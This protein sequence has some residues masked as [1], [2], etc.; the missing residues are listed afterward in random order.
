MHPPIPVQPLDP[1]SR[2][3][4]LR[5]GALTAAVAPE[6]LTP[7]RRRALSREANALLLPAHHL[8]SARRENLLMELPGR[9]LG[10]RLYRPADPSPTGPA[11]DVLLVYF[12][13]GGWVVGD[14]EVHDNVCAFLAQYLGCRLLSMDYRKAPEHPFPAACDDAAD[15]YAWA[16]AQLGRWGCGRIAVAGN[17]AGGHLAAHALFANPA[18]VT[19]AALLFY[20][21]ADMDFGNTSYTQRGAGPGLTSAAMAWYWEQFL[22][23]TQPGDDARAVLMRQQWA[24]RRPPPTVLSIAWHDPL[25]DEGVAYAGL[26][27]RA[28]AQVRLLVAHDMAH[29]FVG[30]CRI[31]AS[32]RRHVEQ[33]ADSL[34]ECLG[35]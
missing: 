11:T 26:L 18:V 19:A 23:N 6:A 24:A 17:S 31:N 3:L 2:E 7:A 10:A 33:A 8:D 34:L 35:G 4:L 16:A 9:S 32:A 13:G 15:A 12:H 1:H 5:A 30:Q 28:G 14:L 29:G 27:E 20:P 22:G 25:H 21:V